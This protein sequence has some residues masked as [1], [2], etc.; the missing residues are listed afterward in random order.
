LLW[1]G[2][3]IRAG[4]AF[5]YAIG[6]GEDGDQRGWLLDGFARTEPVD[7][8]ILG[9][10]AFLGARDLRVRG[11]AVGSFIAAI[12]YRVVTPLEGFV[13]VS[14][15]FPETTA[16]S[17]LPAST[18]GTARHRSRRL[19]KLEPDRLAKTRQLGG[20]SCIGKAC[21]PFA[22]A[23]AFSTGCADDDAPA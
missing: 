10:R 3:R 16:A 19:L 5:T 4:A 20:A 2:L 7:R 23:A 22:L 17:A 15:A 8:L 12:G 21:S 11:D 1:Q 13:S 6:V 14:R 9:V 18:P